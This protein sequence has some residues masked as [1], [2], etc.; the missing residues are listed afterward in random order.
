MPILSTSQCLAPRQRIAVAL[1]AGALMLPLMASPALGELITAT[2][3]LRG[4]T[5]TQA[6]CTAIPQTVWVTSLGR[7]FCVRYYLSTAGGE[8]RRPVVFLQGDKFGKLNLKTRSFY[9]TDKF[10]DVDTDKLAATADGLSKSAKTTAIYLARIGVDGTSGHHSARKSLLELNLMNAALDAIRKRH[11][12][13]GFHLVGQSGGS[14]LVGGLIAMR[15][16]VVCAVPGAGPLAKLK[17]AKQPASKPLD[18]FDAADGIPQI[19]RH[20][21]L[22]ILVVTDRADQ[23]VSPKSQTSF[24]Y[25]LRQAG[26]RVDQFFVEATDKTHHNM[27]P[28]ARLAIS[29]CVQGA[30]TEMIADRLSKLGARFAAAK[31]KKDEQA[32]SEGAPTPGPIAPRHPSIRSAPPAGEVHA[33]APAQ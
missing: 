30:S 14:L 28:Y 29:G 4:I 8:G 7:P 20:R 24:V 18:F 26:G 12:F 5:I 2:D 6:Q 25:Q 10:K 15:D 22:R 27:V 13:E 17:P 11:G 23:K 1:A 32:K 31:A 16:D 33:L 19:V 3:M 9:E 21:A